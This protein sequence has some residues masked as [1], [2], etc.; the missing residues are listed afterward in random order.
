M[1]LLGAGGDVA[2][3]HQIVNRPEAVPVIANRVDNGLAC[4]LRI[5]QQITHLKYAQFLGHNDRDTDVERAYIKGNADV[6]CPAWLECNGD[7]R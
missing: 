2:A 6:K 7:A 1:L 5:D 3:D 4:F